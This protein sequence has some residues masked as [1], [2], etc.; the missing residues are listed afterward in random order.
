MKQDAE[1]WSNDRSALEEELCR[2][3]KGRTATELD[4]AEVTREKMRLEQ[5]VEV[6]TNSDVGGIASMH[7]MCCTV[8]SIILSR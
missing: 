1:I 4:L 6:R 8:D 3:E 7:S 2:V 5:E